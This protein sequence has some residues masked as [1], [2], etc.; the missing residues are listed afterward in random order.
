MESALRRRPL[1]DQLVA[2]VER[3]VGPAQP[4]WWVIP[5]GLAVLRAGG[6]RLGRSRRG[7]A[8]NAARTFSDEKAEPGGWG[9]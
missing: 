3:R 5:G 1:R 2:Y 6:L 7:G 9:A 4:C 8:A